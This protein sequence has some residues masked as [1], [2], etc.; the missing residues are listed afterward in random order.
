MWRDMLF[1]IK[2][3]SGERPDVYQERRV[4]VNLWD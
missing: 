1:N 3:Q 4:S 2:P